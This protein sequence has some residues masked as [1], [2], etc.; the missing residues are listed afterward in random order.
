MIYKAYQRGA[1][2]MAAVMLVVIIVAIVTAMSFVSVSNI[3]ASSSHL[4]S[5]QAFFI[6]RSGLKR[7]TYQIKSGTACASLTNTNLAVGAGSFTTIGTAYPAAATAANLSAAI[8]GTAINIPVT[9]TS[10][11][12][13]N[14]AP[15]G[16]IRIENEEID[17]A[18]TSNA[19][20][21]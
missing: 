20:A 7:A 12:F 4:S 13:A 8:S 21:V 19:A 1:L 3:G 11:A 2:L 15:H 16:R 17:Y 14:Y 18:G 5:A 9:V 10:G 6:A